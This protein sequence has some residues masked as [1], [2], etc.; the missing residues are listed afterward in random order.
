MAEGGRSSLGVDSH[1]A[2]RLPLSAFECRSRVG[3]IDPKDH[4]VHLNR[5]SLRILAVHRPAVFVMENVRGILPAC[6]GEKPVISQILKDLQEPTAAIR[7]SSGKRNGPAGSVACRTWS[8]VKKPASSLLDAKS[9]FEPRDYLI[10]CEKYGVPQAR[11]RVIILGIRDDVSNTPRT[12]MPH[13]RQISVR[14]VIDQL[15]RLR[16]AISRR[17]DSADEWGSEILRAANRSGR[18][19]LK[20][21][22]E[23]C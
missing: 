17:R 3:G 15:P 12:L 22:T 6:V 13:E 16:S 14:E 7:K 10:A 11:H 8:L 1:S 4:R 2:F 20:T 9:Y 18:T 5:E 23:S 19:T 21:P